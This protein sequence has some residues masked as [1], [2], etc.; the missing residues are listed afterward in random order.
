MSVPMRCDLPSGRPAGAACAPSKSVQTCLSQALSDGRGAALTLD[1]VGD[2][3][4]GVAISNPASLTAL[5][6]GQAASVLGTVNS[7]QHSDLVGSGIGFSNQVAGA[8]GIVTHGLEIG[9]FI[10]TGTSF[11]KGL[12]RVGI[13]G[14]VVSTV[15]DGAQAISAY[16]RCRSTP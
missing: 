12:G 2:V 16:A 15:T 10:G 11:T 3:A 8:T 5:V 9:G 6:V 4:L 13:L 14:A 7:I 1:V